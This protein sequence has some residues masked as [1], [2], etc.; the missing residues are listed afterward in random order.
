[1]EELKCMCL[2]EWVA[3]R[4]PMEDSGRVGMGRC[5]ACSQRG[6]TWPG[7]AGNHI[8]LT[9]NALF[10]GS[11]LTLS[12]WCLSLNMVQ[13]Y[14][15]PVRVYKYPFE[16]VMAVSDPWF[17]VPLVA[18]G[19]LWWEG[20]GAFQTMEWERIAELFRCPDFFAWPPPSICHDSWNTA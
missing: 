8:R 13:K 5:H 7:A 14:Q 1:M 18:G 2:F 6:G 11:V 12:W 16:L 17:S 4:V 9:S 10:P 3:L 15:S 20:E 19:Q